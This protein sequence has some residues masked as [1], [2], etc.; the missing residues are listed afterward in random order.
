MLCI[1]PTTSKN[2]PA[3]P[4]EI[5]ISE[6]YYANENHTIFDLSSPVSVS[7]RESF[8]FET[9]NLHA[10]QNVLK[11]EVEMLNI[12]IPFNYVGI[13]GDSGK[14]CLLIGL[15]SVMLNNL[16]TYVRDTCKEDP[17]FVLY[18]ED[19]FIITLIKLQ[20]NLT[21]ELLAHIVNIGKSASNDYFWKWVN[22]LHSCLQF[23]VRIGDR[24]RIF[25]TIT[26]VF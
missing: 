15:A 16:I 17:N 18:R 6:N 2:I 11:E 7:K 3:S 24:V 5:I 14:W 20:H 26:L 13:K 4:A 12:K 8:C 10:K 19:H 22:I 21:F 9:A 1:V 25:Q 23:L